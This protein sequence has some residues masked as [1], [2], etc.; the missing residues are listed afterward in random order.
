MEGSHI[1]RLRDRLH[2]RPAMLALSMACLLGWAAVD[3]EPAH[4]QLKFGG[5]I[6]YADFDGAAFEDSGDLGQVTL[7]GAQIIFPVAERIEL[8]LA[9]EGTSEDLDFETSA[10]SE[11]IKGRAEWNDL[12]L[13]ATGR[14]LLLPLAGGAL[15]VYAGGGAGVH[16]TEV[17]IKDLDDEIAD[18][19]AEVEKESNDF[20]WN[21]MAGASLRLG[22]TLELFGEGRYRDITGEDRPEGYAAYAGLNIVLK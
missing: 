6:G 1:D 16:F 12:A 7:L 21:A 15:N 4:A 10:G 22:A 5:R 11:L 13:Y 3:A 20:E 8:E 9:G 17:K 19:I 2:G 14:L 18:Y